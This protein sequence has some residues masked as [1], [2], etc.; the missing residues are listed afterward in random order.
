MIDRILEFALRQ[1]AVVLLAA[2]GLL[3]AG[4]WSA[5]H[6]PIDAV[7][8]LTGVQVQVNC[9]V[10]ALA[11]EESEQ[12]VTR[13][14]ELQLQ[15]LPGVTAVRSLTKFGLCQVTLTFEDDA[16][17][18]RARQ[19]VNERLTSILDE[20]PPG[21]SPRLAP[22]ST[23]L[24]EIFYY[25][26]HWKAGA[27]ER[28]T[29]GL[30]A[31]MELYDTQEYV[32]K[33]QLRTL[34]GVAE[35]N[36]SGGH[37]RQVLVQPDLDALTR[38]GLTV[39]DLADVLRRNVENA[40][41]G[42]VSREGQQVT[43]RA[44]GRV[45][46][47][48][49]LAEL[50]VKFGA[51]AAPLRVRDLARVGMGARFRTGA[52]SMDGEEVVLGTVMMLSGGNARVVCQH[53]IPRLADVREKLPAG[54]ELTVVYDRSELVDRTIGTV[55]RNL[56]EGAILVVAV[57]LGLLGNWRAALIVALA[58]PLSF[59]FAL[60][61]MVRFGISGNLMSLGAVDFGLII[62]GAVVMVEN[63]VCQLAHRQARLGRTLTPEE[64][65][66]AVLNGSK[67]VGSPMFF[68]VLII[69]L[70]YLP[71][72]ALTGIEGRM[73]RPMALTVI[74]AL[75]GALLLALTLMPVLC[76]YLL[77]GRMTEEDNFLLRPAKRVYAATLQWALRFRWLTVLGSVAVF[78]GAGF[79]YFRLGAEFVP[80][81]DE[82]SITA[83]VYRKVGM[84]LEESLSQDLKVERLIRAQFPEVTRVFA[85]L[86]TSEVATD[87]M[88]PNETDLYVTYRPM[89]EWP[90][91]PGRPT[92][93]RELCEQI[94]QA[95]NAALPGHEFEFAQ[96][97]EMRFN[98]M[99]EGSKAEL[100]VKIF[101][102][103][104]AEL[105][106]LA[107]EVNEVIRAV[108]GGESALEVDGRTSTLRIQVKRAEL[109]RRNL[110]SEEINR[111][112]S[113][114]LG[115]ET[116][117]SL[118]EA[119]RRREIVVRLPDE[120]RADLEV[121]R[122]L[123][124][125]VGE[126]GLLPL[127]PLVDL[128][129]VE[130]VEPIGHDEGRR[131]MA[132][133]VSVHGRDMEGFVQECVGR[134]RERVKFPPG[135]SFEF[136]GQF[137]N[138]RAARARLAVVVP[139]ALLLI[140]G[141]IFAAFRSLRQTFLI[142]TGIPLALTGGILALWIRGMPFSITAAVGFIALSGVAV[143]NG[144]VLLAYFNQLREEGRSVRQ[145][146]EEGA[147]SR[148]RPVLMTAL[149]AA[150]GFVPMALATGAGAEVQRPLATVVIGGILSS[151]FLTLILLP[152]LYAWLEP[153]GKE[154]GTSP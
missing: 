60:T 77:R 134:I 111:A 28:P 30:R 98:E 145:A 112:V 151:T 31:L 71:I 10:P 130:A 91:T 51:G 47:V 131:R 2:L 82:G 35:I 69:T 24:G 115:G 6:L 42:I 12:A 109:V 138:L 94:E 142:A 5:M 52:A 19:L 37:Q 7:P 18:Y 128:E 88:P 79:L 147:L 34:A 139:T 54:M 136:G 59:L 96:P 83:M 21:V 56:F 61:G 87:P 1:R 62:D 143:L 68:G 38:A 25:A 103:E 63:I 104:F 73:F 20:L 43:I 127:G 152:V 89:A 110:A 116:V 107:N 150:L 125:R 17:I 45:Q 81:L 133:L 154:A 36:S 120:Q 135:Y 49:E 32:V 27:V 93:K 117:G 85:R 146:V 74:L 50:P 44:V 80:K 66:H 72:L 67:Q 70:V 121:I 97:I 76:S 113:A 148:L 75:T 15:G 144:L 92:T 119:G 90:R 123:P 140:L 3:A 22:V 33:P 129:F 100:S 53:V 126:S 58:I 40:G 11:P 9:E 99:L 95:V 41:G 16:D 57:L 48:E 13:V 102:P 122:R 4:L 137:E 153:E 78:A 46:S 106:R 124:V 118:W 149:V 55:K 23:G 39:A 65:A 114:S 108:P 26:L 8:D 14:I 86:G 64:H 141:L 105:E 29:N 101:G 132:L 84:S